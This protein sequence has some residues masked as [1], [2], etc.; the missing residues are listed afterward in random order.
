MPKK[1]LQRCLDDLAKRGKI[2]DRGG[3]VEVI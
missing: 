3:V 1:V 2:I